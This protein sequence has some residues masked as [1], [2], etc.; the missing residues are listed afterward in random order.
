[1]PANIIRFVLLVVL[2]L[3]VGTM[4]GIWAGY[5]PSSLS[6]SAYVEQQQNAIRGLNVLLPLM[7]AACILLSLGLA[8]LSSGDPRSRYLLVA[9]AL[10]MIVAGLVT[11]LGNQ[12]INAVV[13]TWSPQ[14]PAANWAQLRDQW[15]QWHVVRSLAGVAALGLAVL[16]VIGARR[17]AS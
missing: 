1:M 10:L 5:N 6:A 7:G 12:P 4:F 15:W 16:A 8:I 13:I 9:A 17:P 14:A 2:A 11:R 3:L